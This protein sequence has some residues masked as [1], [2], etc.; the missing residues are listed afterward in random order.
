ML[1]VFHSRDRS[2]AIHEIVINGSRDS[3]YELHQHI[4]LMLQLND[5]NDPNKVADI[6]FAFRDKKFPS[7]A[8]MSHVSKEWFL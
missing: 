6:F 7:I 5:G 3:K 4:L 2:R 1:S 8:R